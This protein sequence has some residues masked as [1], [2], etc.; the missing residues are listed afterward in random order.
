LGSIIFGGKSL[1]HLKT[2]AASFTIQPTNGGQWLAL[3]LGSP[4]DGKEMSIVAGHKPADPFFASGSFLM[5]PWVNRLDPNPWAREPFYPS[6]HWLTDGNGISLH[7][8]YH[9]LPRV[10]KEESISQSDSFV[11]FSFLLPP[12]WKD[13]VIGKMLV[14]ESFY[15]TDHE[16]KVCYEVKN[17]SD[18]EFLFALGIHPYFCLG[19]ENT[20]DDLYLFG[21]GFSE[22]KLGDFLLPEKIEKESVRFASE[23][24]LEGLNLDNLYKSNVEDVSK[25][26][27]GFFSMNRRERVIVGG[28]SFYQV[29]TPL[30]RKSIAIEPMTATGNF[31]QFEREYA[32]HLGPGE[33][34]KV[35][36]FIRIETF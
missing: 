25:S 29:Y 14:T 8:L 12:E 9:N 18:S 4:L 28:G 7:G 17:T 2:K 10:L 27:F 31:L 20:I 36:F 6:K 21:S 15:L 24:K 3:K 11:S 35:E 19:G 13:T 33:T 30:D 34:K 5:F 26:Y 16:L 1:Y 32:L 23:I 22:V